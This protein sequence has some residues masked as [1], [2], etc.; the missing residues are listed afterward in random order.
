[1]ANVTK[2]LADTAGFIPEVWANEALNV[3]R[4]NIV[5]SRL[6]S[7]DTDYS[8]S[9]VGDTLNIPYPGVFAAQQKAADTAA[10]VQVPSGGATVSVTLDQ[11]WYV[12][13]IV[14][15]V[16]RAQARPE[17]MARYI[18]PAA[19]ALAEKVESTVFAE[20]ANIGSTIG[21]SGTDL[22]AADFRTARKHFND[23]KAPMAN[24]FAVIST[25]DEIALLG[26]SNLASYFANARP[27]A[28][29]QGS[30][31]NLSGFDIYV[32]QLVP[33]VAGSPDST[34]NIFGVPEALML[35][36]RP[37]PDAPAGSGVSSF[38][39]V[40][41]ESGLSMRVQY[42]YSMAD[43]GVRIGFDMLWGVKT[44]RAALAETVLS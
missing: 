32:S 34:K 20:Y 5:L 30:I 31:G 13:F 37:F 2:T 44:I 4:S 39:Q 10:T 38:S 6:V 12:D 27:E 1:M 35:A 33:V 19:V 21:T 8:P 29:S 18:E 25:K 40:D 22:D 11:H 7:K 41:A 15:D 36:T 9:F 28:V 26:D 42:G 24:R 14:E 17:L 43:R 16:A 23:Q 3:L